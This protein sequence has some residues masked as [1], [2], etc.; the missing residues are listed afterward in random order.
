MP[1]Q[2]SVKVLPLVKVPLD[3][4]PAVALDPDQASEAVQDVAFVEI[5]VSVEEPPL[6]I[7]VGLALSDTVGAGVTGAAAVVKLQM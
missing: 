2:F 7:D 4:L 3:W 1:V 5:Q 6:E